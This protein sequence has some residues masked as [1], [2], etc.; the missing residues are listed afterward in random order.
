MLKLGCEATAVQRWRLLGA[1]G[2]DMHKSREAGLRKGARALGSHQRWW[3]SGGG[4]VHV[5]WC[6]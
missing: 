4:A 5:T 2:L 6:S 1:L 3:A